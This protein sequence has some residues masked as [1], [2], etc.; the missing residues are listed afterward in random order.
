MTTTDATKPLA[1]VTLLG[2]VTQRAVNAIRL[3]ICDAFFSIGRDKDNHLSLPQDTA[4]SRH[5]CAISMVGS[6]FL[7]KDLNSSN[8]TYLNGKRIQGTVPLTLPAQLTVG[9]TRLLV[10][11]E[12]TDCNTETQCEQAT[13]CGSGSIVIPAKA[14]FERRSEA[15][16]VVDVIGSTQLVKQNEAQFAAMIVTMGKILQH[17]LRAEAEP[18]LQC[19]GDGFLACFGKARNALDAVLELGPRLAARYNPPPP[20][21]VALHWGSAS[22]SPTG[23]RTGQDVYGVFALEKVR[24]AAPGLTPV[25]TVSG[26]RQLVVMSE[27]FRS[28]L[29]TV[30]QQQTESVGRYRLKG[31][32]GEQQVFRWVETKEPLPA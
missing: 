26:I 29:G 1:S 17:A 23:E 10:A 4:I 21:S 20:L 7:L 18:F 3:P 30:R 24:H 8:G 14:V 31:L 11:P 13:F 5:H 28:K 25:Q 12:T 2:S 19:A 27:R 22:L 16:M 6:A 15:F 9:Q 32:D